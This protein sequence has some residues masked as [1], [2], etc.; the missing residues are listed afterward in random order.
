M[1][2][3]DS[4]YDIFE[5]LVNSGT[6]GDKLKTMLAWFKKDRKGNVI[7]DIPADEFMELVMAAKDSNSELV[8]EHEYWIPP[9]TKA[10]A[11]SFYDTG[12]HEYVLESLE[13]DFTKVKPLFAR[14]SKAA[15]DK[16]A[17]PPAPVKGGKKSAD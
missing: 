16:P 9:A 1:P 8:D 4:G 15:T 5:M 13:F 10:K 2:F 17:D 12:K 7:E 3:T 11:K 14:K 6:G